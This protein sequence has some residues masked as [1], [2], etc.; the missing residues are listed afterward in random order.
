MSTNEHQHL[1]S[2]KI[3][4][5]VGISR[6]TAIHHIKRLIRAGLVIQKGNHYEL[7][8]LS[9]AR[10]IERIKEDVCRFIEEIME[11]GKSIDQSL[12]LKARK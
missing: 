11:I 6:G 5:R 4:A 8:E 12:Q 10:T 9:L 2:D 7:R 1:P 3:A